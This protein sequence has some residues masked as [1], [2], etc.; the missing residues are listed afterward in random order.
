MMFDLMEYDTDA[1][2][3][4]YVSDT[5]PNAPQ[6]AVSVWRLADG[7]VT[8]WLVDAAVGRANGLLV[9]GDELYVGSTQDG[10]LK[11]VNLETRAVR[12]VVGLGAGVVDGIR[13]DG[14]GG[15]LVSLWE[16]QLFR[17]D[18]AGALTQILDLMPSQRNTADFEYLPAQR[19][20]L[21]FSATMPPEITRLAD[22][23]LSN[24]VRIEASRTGATM[25]SSSPKPCPSASTRA[26][27]S[28]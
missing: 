6:T 11:A 18:A 22:Q 17:V 4:I 23:F 19:Q 16:G 8:P 25:S 15:V 3:R 13:S 27:R 5:R 28:R 10:C 12:T 24:P 20:T 2:G 26:A 9:I 14:E 7:V 21:F 1:Q